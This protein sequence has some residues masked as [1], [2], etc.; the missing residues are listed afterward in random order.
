MDEE[1]PRASRSLAT[2]IVCTLVGLLLMYALSSGPVTYLYWSAESTP[3]WVGVIYYPLFLAVH[4]THLDP[5]FRMYTTWWGD[6]GGSGK[7]G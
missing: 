1:K 6:L 7:G 4:A 5:L 3:A 2:R